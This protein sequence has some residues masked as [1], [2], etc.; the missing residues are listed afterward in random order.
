V[1][2][3]RDGELMIAAAN[4]RLFAQLCEAVGRPELADDPRFRTNPDRLANR[5]ELLPL[6]RERI[7]EQSTAHWLEALDGV[8]ASP[9]QDVAQ[10]AAHEQTRA[11]GMVQELDGTKTVALPLQVD[12]E[13]VAHH[14]PPPMLGEQ[15]AEVLAEL[16]YSE[17]EIAALADAGVT[18]LA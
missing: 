10:A 18:R 14:G 3:T 7:A 17:A 2:A 16:G 4:D 1:F 5:G 13:R 8:P 12:H 6:L 9:V 11:T 15:S